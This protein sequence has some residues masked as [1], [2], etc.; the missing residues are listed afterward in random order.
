MHCTLCG[1]VDVDAQNY[2]RRCGTKLPTAEDAE[3]RKKAEG[4]LS[5]MIVFN[6]LSAVFALASVIMLYAT[7]L[8]TPE[9]KWS[10]YV[11]GALCTVIAAHQSVS[12]AFALE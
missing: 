10:I 11:A 8:D 2:C 3:A 4:R 12:F 1:H 7:Y 9:I 6:G 5:S